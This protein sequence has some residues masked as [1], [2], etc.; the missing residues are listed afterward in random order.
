MFLTIAV[1]CFLFLYCC[2]VGS[3]YAHSLPLYYFLLPDDLDAE[4]PQ[5]MVR[6]DMKHIPAE[7]PIIHSPTFTASRR[8]LN[9]LL[10]CYLQFAS[11]KYFIRLAPKI[12]DTI[13]TRL[14]NFMSAFHADVISHETIY[15]KHEFCFDYLITMIVGVFL[16]TT[17]KF[18]IQCLILLIFI[19]LPKYYHAFSAPFH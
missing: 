17:T 1:S 2:V 3:P 4:I 7:Y 10:I 19:N 8:Y 13:N 16:H 18:T 12:A 6:E 15:R 9:L 14:Y 11:L 5:S